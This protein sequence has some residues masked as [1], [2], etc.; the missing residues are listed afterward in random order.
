[1]PSRYRHVMVADPNARATISIL[2]RPKKALPTIDSAP[3]HVLSREAYAREYGASREDLD[4]VHAFAK[5]G[6]LAVTASDSARRTVHVEGTLAALS[7]AFGTTLSMVTIDGG[8]PFR[9]RSGSLSVPAAI[10]DIVRGVFGLDEREQTRRHSRPALRA[11]SGVSPAAVA[12]AYGFPAGTG[13]GQT[14]ALVELGGGYVES[15]LKKYFKKL[16][17]TT[18]TV[19]SVSVNSAKN[20]PT[21][22]ANGPDAEVMLDIEVAGAVAPG[23]KIVAYFAPNTDQGFLDAI[24]T[25]IHDTTHAPSIVSISWGGPESV[26]TAQAT[27]NFDDAFTAAAMLGITVTVAAGDNGST[28]G[29][30]DGL[31]HV[32]FPASSPHVLACGGT[33]LHF[34]QAEIASEVVWNDGSTGGATGGGIS[35]VFPIPMWQQSA[36]VPPSVNAG[37][38]VGR[39]VPDVAGNAD[40]ETGYEVIVD[41]SATVIGGTSA[42][43]PL[44]AGLIARINA[45][46]GKNVGFVNPQLYAM[47]SALRDI[48]SGDNGAY[49][50][51][52]GWDACTG[53]GSPDGPLLESLLAPPLV[54]KS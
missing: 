30:T 16:K 17:M 35:D 40:P 27:R 48:T 41:G 28:D 43:A 45:N 19:S 31:Q 15:D 52:S 2:L 4:A 39:G 22:N 25:A 9:A 36:N 5:A 29:E 26:W 54:K 23:A 37:A 14:I 24:T 18:P 11:R 8:T 20:A 49:V 33:T 50:A 46:A 38:R 47:P 10:G 21:G 51:G 3:V 12:D 34:S 42:V 7:A 13:A 32:D 53:L 6:D 1:M 44:W